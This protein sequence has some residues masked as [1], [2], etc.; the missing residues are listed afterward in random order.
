[1]SNSTMAEI[2]DRFLDKGSVQSNKDLDI[3]CPDCVQDLNSKNVNLYVISSVETYLKLAEALG[4]TR[5]AAVP[6]AIFGKITN[7]SNGTCCTQITASVETTLKFNEAIG[8]LTPNP[9]PSCPSNFNSCINTLKNSLDAEGIDRML[10]KGI[11]E[12]GSLS[13][14]SQVCRIDDFINLSVQSDQ[15]QSTTKAEVLDRILDKG[16]VI[17]CYDDEIV[18]ASVETWLKYAE[19]TGFTNSAAVPA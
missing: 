13:G 18:M 7:Q 3:C 16:I 9:N 6:A 5:Q 2:L 12:Y 1:M 10:D 15:T 4:F 8:N 19:A 17:S 11:V 14:V